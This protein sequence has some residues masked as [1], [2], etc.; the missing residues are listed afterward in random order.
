MY[1]K[2]IPK[3]FACPIEVTRE[4]IGGKWKPSIIC[5]LRRGNKRPSELHKAINDA[6][7]RVLNQQLKELEMHGI[8]EKKIYPVVPA[9]VEYT[10]TE[11]GKSLGPVMDMMERWGEEYKEIFERRINEQK[12]VDI[13]D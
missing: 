8:I 11:F 13:I 7:Q 5:Y 2:K 10:L 1:E 3:S 4:V 6:S 9:R 12:A